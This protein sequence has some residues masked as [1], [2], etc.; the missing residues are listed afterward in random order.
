MFKF[1]E[2]NS[3]VLSR[4]NNAL[5]ALF[6]INSFLVFWYFANSIIGN[7]S[8]ATSILLLLSILT[9]F[10]VIKGARVFF[11]TQGWW[12]LSLIFF[13][14]FNILSLLGEGVEISD[15]Y[16]KP[17]KSLAAALIF[18]YL[19]RYGFS[20]KVVGIAIVFST[21]LGGGYA[22]YEKFVLDLPRAGT[23]TNPIRY[24]Y[25]ILTLALLCF[26]YAHYSE[27]RWQKMFFIIGGCL[28]L[29]GAYS[30]GTRGVVVILLFLAALFFV[31]L[32]KK[33]FIS[34]SRF[35]FSTALFLLCI[36]LLATRTDLLGSYVDK[37][38]VEIQ[39]I[40]EGN[41][42]TSIGHRLQMWH[43]AIYLGLEEPLTGAGHD[44]ALLREKAA[45]FIQDHNYNPVILVRYGHFHN[46]YLDSFAKQGVPGVLVWVFFLVGA[47][48]GMK[49]RYRYAVLFIVATLAVGGLTE[50]VL[51]SSRLF[52]LAILGISIFRCLDHFESSKVAK[53][54]TLGSK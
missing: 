28:G 7:K 44:Y 46:Q 50:A 30:T 17:A 31:L 32:V 1:H 13:G 54:T 16:D 45:S 10:P 43:V 6:L 21:L 39:T 48:L 35:G 36:F 23:M 38:L 19:L 29:L 47:L 18:L 24:G 25:L 12:V 37:T 40:E 42:N 4:K 33:D 3:L 52:Y 51:R 53:L 26:F 14:L 15:A 49:T 9:I 2:V 11:N 27:K 20:D 22:V 34:W 41:L 8:P 5:Y